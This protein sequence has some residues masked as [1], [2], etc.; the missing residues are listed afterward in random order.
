MFTKERIVK[1]ICEITISVAIDAIFLI[2]ILA[3]HVSVVTTRY[4][5]KT[6]HGDGYV[7]ADHVKI[8]TKLIGGELISE[9]RYEVFYRQSFKE[10]LE[11]K[12]SI[13]SVSFNFR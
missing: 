13:T 11:D 2:Y 8:E 7:Y 5:N 10:F 3:P 9:D 6:Y 4:E 1:W 12:S